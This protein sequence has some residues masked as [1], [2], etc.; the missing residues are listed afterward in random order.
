MKQYGLIGEKLGHSYSKVLHSFLADYSY[1][2][3]PMPKS[4]LA[5]FMQAKEFAGINVTIPYKRDVIPFLDEMGETAKRIGCVNTVVG[6]EDGT[7]YGDNTDAY[8]FMEMARRAGIDFSLGKTLVLGSGGTSLTACAVIREAGGE[9][10]VVSRSGE[11]RYED[12]GKHTDAL[13]LVNTPP[14]GMY[15]H[16][17]AA[18]VDL[19]EL[20]RLQGVLDVIYNPLKTRLLQQAEELGIAYAGGLCMLVYQ[21]VRACELF[22]GEA[23][24]PARIRRAERELMKSA[25][26]LV[27]VGMPGC[28]KTTMGDILA[29]LLELELIDID[30]EIAHDAGISIPEIFQK[31]GEAGFRAREAAQIER[32]GR[33]G[34]RILVTGGGA[35]KS[36]QNRENL[37]LNG[38]VV[39]ITRELDLLP[40][41][42]RPLSTSADALRIM[43]VERAPM[44]HAC[45][46]AVI[47]NNGRPDHCAQA[48]KEAYHEALCHQRT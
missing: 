15:P 46:D 25:M 36:P 14:V 23:V 45:A 19:R 17:D 43:W 37:S 12:L 21:A 24:D 35:V 4:S 13:F 28:G 34:G 16:T 2:L 1:D 44:Y 10:I 47:S 33:E 26:N 40:M 3:W 29:R 6:R 20:P 30:Q 27:I 11:T 39:H 41:D 9:A 5:Q 48:I 42:G 7:L 22:T 38:F 18:A 32:Y 8:G 31:E